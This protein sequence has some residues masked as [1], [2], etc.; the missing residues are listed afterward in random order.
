LKSIE[1]QIR[2]KKAELKAKSRELSALQNELK[3]KNEPLTINRLDVSIRR[4]FNPIGDEPIA[5][6]PWVQEIHMETNKYVSNAEIVDA[7]KSAIES[8]SETPEP[9]S[10]VNWKDK[11]LDGYN[12]VALDSRFVEGEC[13]YGFCMYTS[14]PHSDGNDHWTN[15]SDFRKVPSDAI[16]GPIPAW[17]KSLIHR[18]GVK[19]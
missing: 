4:K 14:I 16:I 2:D 1:D 9:K 19:E 18:P 12:W 13:G 10:Y 15:G 6:W 7:L 11:R 3:K 5:G 8:L 17:D